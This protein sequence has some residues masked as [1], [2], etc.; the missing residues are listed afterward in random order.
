MITSRISFF[1][2]TAYA[3]FGSLG[4]IN[5]EY[6]SNLD[7]AQKYRW[8]TVDENTDLETSAS[9]NL[10]NLSGLF[11]I[12]DALNYRTWRSSYATELRKMAPGVAALNFTNVAAGGFDPSIW[13]CERNHSGSCTKEAAMQHELDWQ[14][15]LAN[16]PITHCLSNKTTDEVCRLE[17]NRLILGITIGCDIVKIVVIVLAL[18]I[19]SDPPLVTI[20]DGI[21]M[22]LENPEQRTRGRSLVGQDKT[23][24]DSNFPWLLPF[25][26]S[27]RIGD[28]KFAE[29]WPEVFGPQRTLWVVS[30]KK[31]R[32][33]P[34]PQR[35][36]LCVLL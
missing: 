30:R 18:C 35:W 19:I 21:A 34:S 7:F 12:F 29:I 17:Y 26:I 10:R 9:E 27:R 36:V 15:T 8:Y 5:S 16:I 32:H 28:K 6:L 23:L 3:D 33:A 11:G 25:D 2:D 22:F 4:G 13:M 20:G 14:V 24:L 31:W 1:A